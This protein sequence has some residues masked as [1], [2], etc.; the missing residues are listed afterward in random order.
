MSL[1]RKRPTTVCLTVAVVVLMTLL[2][3]VVVSSRYFNNF[4]AIDASRDA[5]MSRVDLNSSDICT[6]DMFRN[7]Y[8]TVDYFPGEGHWESRTA[9]HKCTKVFLRFLFRPINQSLLRQK[10]ARK[11]RGLQKTINVKARSSAIAL[12]R[13]LVMTYLLCY[14]AL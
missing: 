6:V 4:R 7:Y 14:G 11:H 13:A 3:L 2:C 5:T 9:N 10:V 8:R 1:K 12:M